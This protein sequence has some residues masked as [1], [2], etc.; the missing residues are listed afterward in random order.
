MTSYLGTRGHMLP[1]LYPVSF[2]E[3]IQDKYTIQTAA[4]RTWAFARGRESYHLKRRWSV[5]LKMYNREYGF[6][7]SLLY[8]AFGNDALVFIPESAA[9]TNVLT[10][11][12]S[13]LAGVGNGGAFTGADGA[14]SPVSVVGPEKVTLAQNVPVIPGKPVTV[15]VDVVGPAVLEVDLRSVTGARVGS[16]VSRASS[17]EGVQRLSYVVPKAPATAR[18]LNVSVSGYVVAAFPQV[19]YTQGLTP[20][21]V[22]GGAGQVVLM[23]APS[24]AQTNYLPGSRE[25]LRSVELVIQEVG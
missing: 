3:D 13:L 20:W 23:Q 8:G 11:A 10:P 18:T 25:L 19:T 24:V 2:S 14:V 5:Q 17:G 15:T 21:E 4:T 22:G 16:V 12:Q 6:I 9:L 1:L 7:R